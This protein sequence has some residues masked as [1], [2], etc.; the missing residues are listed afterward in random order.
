MP[1]LALRMQPNANY[2]RTESFCLEA[3]RIFNNT[4]DYEEL[5]PLVLQLVL[6]AVN[7]EAALVFRIDHERTDEN[8]ADESG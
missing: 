8:A 4:N 3:A 2:T 6:T 5:I 1:Y 7:A